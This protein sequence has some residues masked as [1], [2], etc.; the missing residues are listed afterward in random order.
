MADCECLQRCP[1]FNDAMAKMPTIASFFKEK[2]CKGDFDQCARYMVFKAKGR[3]A[4][5]VD[6][7]PDQVVRARELL[8]AKA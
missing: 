6:L 2:L 5:P 1:F 4:V 7:F 8:A 3:E